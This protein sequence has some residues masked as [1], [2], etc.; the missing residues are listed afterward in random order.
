MRTPLALL[1]FLG[2]ALL[3]AAGVAIF[4]DIADF[5]LDVGPDI[6]KDVWDWWD[7]GRNED[8]KRAELEALARLPAPEAHAA[9]ARV[10]EDPG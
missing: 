10:V 2:K 9:A 7:P 5:L 4:G 6:V 8:D 1:R 3:S